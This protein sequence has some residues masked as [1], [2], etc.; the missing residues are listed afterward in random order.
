MVEPIT[1][2][3]A[4]V[5]TQ[6]PIN[7]N[8]GRLTADNIRYDGAI[9]VASN[10][11]DKPVVFQTP[12]ARIEAKSLRIDT[13]KRTLQAEG[14]VY[15]ERQ[16]RITRAPLLASSIDKKAFPGQEETVTETLRGQDFRYDFNT[17]KGSIDKAKLSLTGFTVSTDELLVNG[18]VYTAKNVLLR[19]GG[20]TEK[21]TELYG[22][23]PFNFRAKT[24]TVESADSATGATST[25]ENGAN[26]SNPGEGLAPRARVGI[27]GGALYFKNTKLLPVPSYVFSSLNR[28]PRDPQTFGL[29]PRFNFNSVDRVLVTTRLRYP[30]SKNPNGTALNADVGLSARIGLRGGVAL[31]APTRFGNFGLGLRKSDIVTTQLTNRIELDR[32]PELTFESRFLPLLRLP[33]KRL[34]GLSFSAGGGRFRERTIGDSNSLVSTDRSQVQLNFTT[35][36]ASVAGPYLD[37]FA[38]VASY[39]NRAEK[40]KNSG[41]EIGYAGKMLP[42]VNGVLS[43]RATSLSGDTPFRFDRVEIARELRGT[44]DIEVTPRYIVPLDL[45][46]DLDKKSFRDRTFGVL[47]N[48]KTFAYGVV[49]QTSRNELRAEIRQGF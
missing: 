20:L 30:L 27:T 11:S 26:V 34:A 1:E 36:G 40:Y 39:G 23:P 49:Y 31:E 33:G 5:E 13:A 19:P 48:Y 47:R 46:Y 42:R 24:L 7:P 18:R 12:D 22:T 35:R 9:L 29:T 32:T 28:G 25:P 21:E 2:P 45:R 38:R 17:Q 15:I 4:S 41:F 8:A 6:L 14:N 44:V 3:A 37:I 43:Y 10:T 16:R